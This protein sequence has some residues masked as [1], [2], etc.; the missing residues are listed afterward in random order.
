MDIDRVPSRDAAMADEHRAK[1]ALRP[2]HGRVV[3]RL[4]L[5]VAEDKYFKRRPTDKDMDRVIDLL[6]RKQRLLIWQLE[7]AGFRRTPTRKAWPPIIET[8]DIDL[9]LESRVCARGFRVERLDEY[10]VDDDP[11]F[12]QRDL[13]S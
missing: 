1:E 2:R 10:R 4:A 13:P 7:D 6:K 11:S 9:F 5:V 3:A 12:F 8:N